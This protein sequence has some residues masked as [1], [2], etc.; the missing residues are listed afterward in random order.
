MAH[1]IAEQI[2]LAEQETGNEKN[3]AKKS[4]FKTILNLWE[5]HSSFPTGRRPFENFESIFRILDRF[6]PENTRS[7]YFSSQNIQSTKSDCTIIEVQKWLDI[8]LDIDRTAR[9]LIDFAFKQAAKNAMDDKT[10]SWLNKL[11]GLTGDLDVEVIKRLVLLDQDNQGTEDSTPYIKKLE[12][13][14]KSKIGMLDKFLELSDAVR[15]ALLTEIETISKKN[16]T[17]DSKV[18]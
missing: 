3:D 14:I 2:A 7:L 10:K 5:H 12:N 11:C 17:T 8:A 18:K 1:Y 9:V 6:D 15:D 4:C 16:T 13:S